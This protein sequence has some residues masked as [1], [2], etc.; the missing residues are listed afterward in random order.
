VSSHSRQP[1]RCDNFLGHNDP[2]SEFLWELEV[3]LPFCPTIDR[4]LDALTLRDRNQ[5]GLD[6]ADLDQPARAQE[7]GDLRGFDAGY[8]LAERGKVRHAAVILLGE[9]HNYVPEGIMSGLISG[10]RA[11]GKNVTL[12]YELP[13]A[14]TN[15]VPV[16]QNI[17]DRFN[18]GDITPL[19]MGRLMVELFRTHPDYQGFVRSP[20]DNLAGVVYAL[21]EIAK[22]GA[23]I[24]FIDDAAFTPIPQGTLLQK[25][26]K[27]RDELMAERVLALTKTGDTIVVGT[28]LFHAQTTA[29]MTSVDNSGRI[30]PFKS[31]ID[32]PMGQILKEALGDDKIYSTAAL[33]GIIPLF[34]DGVPLDAWDRVIFEPDGAYLPDWIAPQRALLP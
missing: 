31:D 33:F 21:T 27:G 9:L 13:P 32:Q 29:R 8:Q 14:D 20:Q 15:G 17:A 1:V 34:M 25:A 30:I 5:N 10:L 26:M 11:Q 2:V 22:S 16:L 28:G 19:E 24:Q 23:H 7:M 12:A 18:R 3:G 4:A 6:N